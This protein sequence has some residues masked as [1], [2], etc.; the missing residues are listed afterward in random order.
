MPS[1]Q[2][3]EPRLRTRRRSPAP[4]GAACV[5]SDAADPTYVEPITT[6]GLCAHR[7]QRA[8]GP[9]SLKRPAG[10]RRPGEDIPGDHI[11]DYLGYAVQAGVR[12]SSNIEFKGQIKA[13]ILGSM[14]R[15]RSVTDGFINANSLFA[16]AKGRY[17]NYGIKSVLSAGGSHQFKYGD[18]FY[19]A[20][21]YWK[22]DL[23]WYFIN[24]AKVKG[25][26]NL[27]FHLIDWNDLDQQQQLSIIYLFGK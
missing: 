2:A 22:T 16:E 21:N 18:R 1:A 7:M 9:L 11:K 20:K 27:S 6:V 10:R 8:E 3:A 25:R 23:I 5:S 15:E 24:H 26:F 12:T 4:R 13:G 14:F 17:K 19:R